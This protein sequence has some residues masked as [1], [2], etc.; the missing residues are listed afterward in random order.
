MELCIHDTT[1]TNQGILN[2]LSL[3]LLKSGFLPALICRDRSF[4]FGSYF[5]QTKRDKI[6]LSLSGQ[7][8]FAPV[9]NMHHLRC[10]IK[11]VRKRERK[12]ERI[13]P[14]FM[15]FTYLYLDE[16]VNSGEGMNLF[17]KD[18][19]LITILNAYKEGLILF[20]ERGIPQ[21][22][23]QKIY[24]IIL[25]ERVSMQVELK[26][27]RGTIVNRSVGKNGITD[28]HLF[29]I[30]ARFIGEIS[31]LQKSIAQTIPQNF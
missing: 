27:N 18:M 16:N 15:D 2:K 13:V 12:R 17:L 25:Q 21:K 5:R 31:R 3:N 8:L 7:A 1:C 29:D 6:P 20:Y 30:T 24:R 9:L 4:S 26:G 14:I 11:E 23:T 10:V 28:R 19:R 22:E